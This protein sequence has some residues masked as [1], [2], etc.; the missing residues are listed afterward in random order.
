MCVTSALVSGVE[1]YLTHTIVILNGCKT[2][3]DG[4]DMAVARNSPHSWLQ[5]IFKTTS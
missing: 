1:H 4:N 5:L 3:D 2:D